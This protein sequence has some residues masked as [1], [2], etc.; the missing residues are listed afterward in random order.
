M[1][2]ASP[3]PRADATSDDPVA[4]TVLNEIGIIAQL[5]E[6]AFEARLAG[7]MR[8]AHFRVLNHF[9]R[10]GGERSMVRL[11][12]A[13]QLTKGAMTNTVARLLARGYVTVRAD[14]ADARSKLVSLTPAGRSARD[15]AL[16]AMGSE[17]ARLQAAFPAAAWPAALP[18]LAG[19][20]RW[21]DADRDAGREAGNG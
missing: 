4:F 20:R 2:P 3:P 7:G 16:A 17:L 11:A 15:A 10:L 21:L 19:L 9:A 6:A 1:A 8:L 5:S 14:P 12:D 18:F 13:F